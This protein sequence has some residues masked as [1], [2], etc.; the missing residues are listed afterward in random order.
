[1]YSSTNVYWKSRMSILGMSVC[2]FDI[3]REKKKWLKYLQTMET[4]IRRRNMRRL[5][6]VFTVC[7]LP[8]WSLQTKS[9]FRNMLYLEIRH[10]ERYS[11]T[12]ANEKSN[13]Y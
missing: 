5:I 12:M 13:A 11:Y 9:W 10:L 4:L 1:M 2:D 8:F 7:Q 6:W 3:S